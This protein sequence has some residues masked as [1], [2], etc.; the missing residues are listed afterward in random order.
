MTFL[1]HITALSGVGVGGGSLVYANTLPVPERDFFDA[2]HWRDMADWQTEL[3]PHYR[4]ALRML[5][6]VPF[7]HVTTPDRVLAEVAREKGLEA[8][9]P[10]NVAVFFG[11]PNVT[12]PD[13]YFGGAGP[14]RAGC[15]LCGGCMVGCRYNAK[16]TLDKN[17]LYFAEKLGV[18]ILPET[19][20]RYMD[21]VQGG[22]YRLHVERSTSP[23][24]KDRRTIEAG[25]VVLAAGALGTVPLLLECV[26]RGT[27]PHLS[28]QLGHYTRTNSEALLGVSAWKD[29]PEHSTGIAITS[30]FFLGDG[31]RVE[32]V[33]YSKGSDAMC[34]LA[35]PLTDGHARDVTDSV[36]IPVAP[37]VR[38][39]LRIRLA[40][41]L[42]ECRQAHQ[43]NANRQQRQQCRF[44]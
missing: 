20:V 30:H 4:T 38:C 35:T 5:G 9:Q 37:C 31:T 34:M 24:F 32:P 43:N 27:L 12:V 22:G 23:L 28:P 8:P 1:R 21:P 7:P 16:N 29:E 10:T 36:P 44:H 18:Q 3:E 39:N 19:R 17:Y 2:P 11:K 25:G 42:G 40:R 41:I 33:R 14:E 26:R 15:N 13:P 6:A